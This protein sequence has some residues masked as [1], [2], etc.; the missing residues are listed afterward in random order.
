[1][2]AIVHSLTVLA[3]VLVLAPLIGYLPMAGLA[4]LLLLVAWNMSEVKHFGHMLRVAR[5]A[6]CWCWSPAT[7]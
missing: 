2:A 4:A 1:V 5:A 3:A 7:G 6:T